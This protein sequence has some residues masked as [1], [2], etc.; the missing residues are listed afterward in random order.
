MALGSAPV[1][2]ELGETRR[3]GSGRE[4]LGLL[5]PGAGI[6]CSQQRGLVNSVSS[7]CYNDQIYCLIENGRRRYY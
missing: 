3:D 7:L 5:G 2:R 6:D 1:L 4:K